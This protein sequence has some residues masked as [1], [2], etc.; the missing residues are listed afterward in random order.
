MQ[1]PD[2]SALIW[3]E[4]DAEL[5]REP[6]A[7]QRRGMIVVAHGAGQGAT[8]GSFLVSYPIDTDDDGQHV[9]AVS[10][11]LEAMGW[12]LLAA[13]R[14]ETA[15]GH[16]NAAVLVS[17]ARSGSEQ[18]QLWLA[19][20]VGALQRP[21][22][23]PSASTSGLS[24]ASADRGARTREVRDQVEAWVNEGGAGDDVTS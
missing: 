23:Q 9:G 3:V 13:R 6:A 20:P 15:G 19:E 21:S 18:Q 17:D 11:V 5:V 10:G 14:G 2:A 24:G 1:P 12:S 16:V 8:E 4:D 7:G 22:A